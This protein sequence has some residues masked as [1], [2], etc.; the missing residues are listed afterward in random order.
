[1]TPEDRFESE[2]PTQRFAVALHAALKDSR[3]PRTEIARRMNALGFER[4]NPSVFG[5]VFKGERKVT[6]DEAFALGKLLDFDVVAA[7]VPDRVPP[8]CECSPSGSTP[9]DPSRDERVSSLLWEALELV[10]GE[11]RK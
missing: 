6:L 2:R 10:T 1:M 3:L 8:A 5:L 11:A 7:L 4:F 9:D